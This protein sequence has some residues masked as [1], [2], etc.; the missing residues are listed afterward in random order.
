LAG[1]EIVF[2]SFSTDERK[3]YNRVRYFAQARAFENY[4]YTVISGNTGNLPTI[5]NY[6]MNYCRSAVFTPS[7][8]VF[9]LE[10]IAGEAEPNVEAVVIADLDMNDLP[11][12]REVG[13]VI[14][15]FDRSADIYSLSPLK[16]V[17]LVRFT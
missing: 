9:P 8:F 11:L 1:A 6:L 3:A 2:V 5:K 15:F 16:D 14:P 12:Q 17:E 13:S 7:D 4:F 10:G